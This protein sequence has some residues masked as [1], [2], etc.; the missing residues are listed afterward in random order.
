MPI[1][2]P[3]QEY[4]ERWG[5]EEFNQYCKLLEQHADAALQHASKVLLHQYI[6]NM[7]ISAHLHKRVTGALPTLPLVPLAT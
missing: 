3:Y 1:A 7:C 2:E 4:A 5:S 6:L